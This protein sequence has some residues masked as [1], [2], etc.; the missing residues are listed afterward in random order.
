M[1]AARPLRSLETAPLPAGASA[2]GPVPVARPLMPPLSAIAPYIEQVDALRWYTN[3]GPLAQA[4]EARLVQR[5]PRPTSIVTTTNGTQALTLALQAM[6][7]RPGSLCVLPSWTFAATAHAVMAAGL[8]P[9][10]V[11][12]DPETGVL[13]AAHVAERLAAAP[14]PVAALVPVALF[15]QPFDFAPWTAL[16]AK[17]SVPVLVDAA[18]SFDTLTEAPL[19]TMVS[20]HAT[21]L[22]STGEGGMLASEDPALI[23]RLRKMT[24]FGFWGSRE[25]QLPG[26]NAKL[27]EYSAAV[28]LASLD[29]W[30]ARRA[31]LAARAQLMRAALIKAPWIRFQP[32]WG[33]DW[34][35]STCCVRIEGRDAADIERRL[36]DQ[37]VA[38]RRWWGDGCHAQAAFRALPTDPLP[39]TE[40][41]ARSTLGLPFFADMTHDDINRVSRAILDLS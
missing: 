7:T 1:S 8:V 28:G 4:L 21:K 19:P 36:A 9:W 34:I 35:S 27:S 30:P 39:A 10:F 40:A 13:D 12:V 37:G 6:D 32:G 3:F 22:V 24:N 38:T 14:G 11:D 25:A 2:P 5:F 41:L 20:L 18:A 29:Q 15:G 23:E 31:A 33:L 16:R 26:G 17:T